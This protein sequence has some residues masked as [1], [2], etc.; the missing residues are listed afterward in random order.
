MLP[1]DYQNYYN[2]N[3]TA[4]QEKKFKDKKT[5]EEQCLQTGQ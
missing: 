4:K 2:L 5:N 1:A 3:H